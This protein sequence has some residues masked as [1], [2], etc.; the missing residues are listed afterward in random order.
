MEATTDKKGQILLTVDDNI[1]THTLKYT[2]PSTSETLTAKVKV[3]SRFSGN[4]NINMYYFDGT[5]YTVRVYGDWGKPEGK[6]HIVTIK[7][8]KKTYKVKTNKNGYATLKIPKTV[9]PGSHKIT[10]TY[11]GQTVK[12][13]L[14]IKQ[15]LKTKKTVKVKKSAK[16]LILKAT[17]K[18]GKKP[19]KGK[20]VTFKIIGKTYKAK[21]NKKGIAKVTVK[22]NVIKKLKKG[23]TY[24]V[25]VTYLKDTIKTK[26][27]VR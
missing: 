22:K 6:N 8:D 27:K 10:A 13:T 26:V 20:K 7:I 19:I 5:K 14:K 9:T 11:V 3:V 12:N 17:L 18:N 4:K 24:T 25:K 2:N 1:G 21:T 23:K 16:K 15:V